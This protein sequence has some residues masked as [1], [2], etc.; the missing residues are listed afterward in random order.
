MIFFVPVPNV[1]G[2]TVGDITHNIVHY[3]AMSWRKHIV[4]SNSE[5]IFASF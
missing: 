4:S 1:V 2:L 3:P 5:Q